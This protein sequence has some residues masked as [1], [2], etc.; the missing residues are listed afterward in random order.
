MESPDD[1]TENNT[2][3]VW[4]DVICV[5]A[6]VVRK[7]VVSDGPTWKS[8]KGHDIFAGESGGV[9]LGGEC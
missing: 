1:I 7:K 6:E 9:S 4:C 5:E 8:F 2:K 3:T